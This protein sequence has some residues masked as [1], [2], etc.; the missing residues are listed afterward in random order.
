MRYLFSLIGAFLLAGSAVSAQSDIRLF[1]SGAEKFEALLADMQQAQHHIHC[2]YFIFADDSIAHRMLDVMKAKAGE[3][4][5]VRLV[6]DG[7]YDVKRGYNY[8]GRLDQLRR[9]GIDIHI[10]KPYVF[11][12]VHRVLRDHRKIVVVDG[13]IGYTGG[14]NVADYN[15]KGKDMY[16]GYIDTHVRLEGPEVEDLQF[17]FA[18]HLEKSGGKPFAGDAYYPY[19]AVL[20]EGLDDR[21]S[22]VR[23]VERGRSSRQKKAEMRREV[24]AFIDSAEV[25]LHIQSPYLMPT[26]GVRRALR[27]ALSRG[28]KIEVLFSQ[29]GDTP[30]FDTG[31]VFYSHQLQKRGARVWLYQGAFQHSK[32][33]TADGRRSLVGSANLD[34]RALRWNEEVAAVIDDREATLWLDSAFAGSVRQSVGMTP[35]YYYNLPLKTRIKGAMTDFFLSWCL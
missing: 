3:G 27:R 10:Y 18:E 31:N 34:Y 15:I 30:L 33:L 13:R 21:Q 11:P 2:E 26:P 12:Y 20:S 5:E 35:Q 23:I 22:S 24:I 4:V 14:F 7:Y 32:V 29:V 17:L 8:A 16:G 25:S 6:V 28:V 1:Q 19:T 9:E